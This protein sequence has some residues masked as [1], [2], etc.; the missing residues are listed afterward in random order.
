MATQFTFTKA[1]KTQSRLRL[2]IAAPSGAGK[3]YTSLRVARALA[4][5]DGK[6]AVID[7]ERGSASKYAHLFEF[8]VLELQTF[9]PETYVQAIKAAEAAEYDVIVIDSL[10]H[11]WSGKDGALE[12]VDNA[13]VRSKGNSYAAWREVTPHHNA[14]VDAMLGS[15]AHIIATMRSKTEYVLETVNG[16]QVP[17][18][19]GMA[20]VQRDGM[21]YEFDVFGEMD[22][23]NRLSITKT[24]C[25]TLHN[26]V[27]E[28]PGEDFAATLRAW[29]TDGVSEAERPTPV[30][31]PAQAAPAQPSTNNGG[32]SKPA[33]A[34][35]LQAALAEGG[36]SLA[37]L[38]IVLGERPT[39]AAIVRWSESHP[40]KTVTDLV[41]EAVDAHLKAAEA[42][43]DGPGLTA[44]MGAQRWLTE[45]ATKHKCTE[46]DVWEALGIIG[47]KEAVLEALASNLAAW[48]KQW[49]EI[50]TGDRSPAEPVE[51]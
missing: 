26:A 35:A 10:S 21:E 4:G 22:Q 9:A 34:D 12:Q 5:P 24:R 39:N 2:A 19:V 17:R 43:D 23:Q 20:P 37:D 18:K 27:I 29:L 15:S 30:T 41:S 8:D 42:K 3:T 45:Q 28:K 51:A 13:A 31:A 1:T 6:V 7:T 40:D 47:G 38:Q 44:L 33:W 36:I 16:K 14:L 32:K 48:S 11:A 50:M 25:D 49:D 46:Q